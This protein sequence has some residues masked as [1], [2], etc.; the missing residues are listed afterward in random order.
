MIANGDKSLAQDYLTKYTHTLGNLT[1][2]GYNSNL[3][4]LSFQKK[5]DRKN[6]SGLNIG[7]RNGLR[8]NE[9]VVN[10]DKWTIDDITTRTD[11]LVNFFKTSFAL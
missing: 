11:S 8:L 5:K 2:T 3:S 6:N 7:Y 9:D 10:K 4:N 1:I